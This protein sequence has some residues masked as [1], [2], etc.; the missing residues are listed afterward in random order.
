[1]K[2]SRIL[3]FAFIS[4]FAFTA[5]EEDEDEQVT[6][7]TTNNNGGGGNNTGGGNNSGYPDSLNRMTNNVIQYRDTLTG[8]TDSIVSFSYYYVED[9]KL[10]LHQ[11]S[12]RFSTPQATLTLHFI[13][14]AQPYFPAN[15]KTY[16]YRTNVTGTRPNQGEWGF[17]FCPADRLPNSVKDCYTNDYAGSFPSQ[18]VASKGTLYYQR[19]GDTFT[20]SFLDYRTEGYSFSGKFTFTNATAGD[21]N[22]DGSFDSGSL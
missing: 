15:D 4:V 13:E 8:A 1:M 9:G 3:L 21:P 2:L 17:R 5:C 7:A 10:Y 18:T 6:P 22:Y 12:N 11:L 19:S 16:S 20:F 14:G